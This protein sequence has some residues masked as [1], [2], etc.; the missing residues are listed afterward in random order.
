MKDLSAILQEAGCVAV[1]TYIQSGNAVFL[2]NIASADRFADS[3]GRAIERNHGFRPAMFLLS[4]RDLD[5][6]IAS[7]P[8]PEAASEPKSLHVYFL[9]KSPE[10]ARIVDARALLANSESLVQVGRCLYLRAPDGIARSRFAQGVDRV[11][12]MNTTARNWRTIVKLAE[13]AAETD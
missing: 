3:V 7:N 6:A 9:D 1:K 11:L 4:A 12:G 2:A 10:K 5:R 8:F 13:L